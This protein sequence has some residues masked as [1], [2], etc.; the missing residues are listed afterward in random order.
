MSGDTLQL[1]IL[2]GLQSICK[3]SSFKKEPK[4][5][6]DLIYAARR[7]EL[8]IPAKKETYVSL[9]AKLNKLMQSLEDSKTVLLL[10]NRIIQRDQKE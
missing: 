8:T 7:A 1:A 3:I 5:L 4:T 6:Q 10:Y 2:N 9:H